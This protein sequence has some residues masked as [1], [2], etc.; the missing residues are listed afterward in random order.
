[1]TGYSHFHFSQQ[2]L[3]FYA[4]LC[5][6][7]LW[8]SLFK[9]HSDFVTYQSSVQKGPAWNSW[10]IILSECATWCL[11][12]CK[13]LLFCYGTSKVTNGSECQYI[14]EKGM[15]TTTG[16]AKAE[17]L[18]ITFPT[19]PSG[20][21]MLECVNTVYYNFAE[22]AKSTLNRSRSVTGMKVKISSTVMYSL[23]FS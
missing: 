10:A 4:S 6:N 17:L 5:Y 9:K 7:P 2:S 13:S 14:T 1:M 22:K 23:M 8:C 19:R 11:Q 12:I 15:L 21:C 18:F 16:I 3:I 20:L